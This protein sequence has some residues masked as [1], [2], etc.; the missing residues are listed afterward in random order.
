MSS[1]QMIRLS[2]FISESIVD[3]EGIRCVVFAQGCPHHCP[4]C[5]NPATHSFDGGELV[6]VSEIIAKI[7]RLAPYVDGVTLSGGEPF[8]QPE[9]FAQIAKSAKRLGLTVWCYTGY[10]FEQLQKIPETEPLLQQIDVLVDGRFI[11]SER[12]LQTPFRGSKNQRLI[13]VEKSI[14]QNQPSPYL[15]GEESI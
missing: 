3:G 6:P 12:S 2:G 1:T 11:L 10:Q 8:C 9:A 13:D 5:H 7:Q 14:R 4:G 15:L